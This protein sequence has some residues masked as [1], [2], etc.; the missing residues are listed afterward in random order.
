MSVANNKGT[1]VTDMDLE[2]IKI[3]TLIVANTD[4]GCNKTPP[5]G[6]KEISDKLINSKKV[7]VKMYSGGD[8]PI[9]KPCNAMSY[10][11]FLGIENSVVDFIATFIK[12]N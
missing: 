8:K 5:E 1:S 10:H 6:A 2:K 4:D 12:N 9:S 3:P 11:G 7:N